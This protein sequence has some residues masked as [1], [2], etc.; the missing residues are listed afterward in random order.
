MTEI[1]VDPTMIERVARAIW[2][3]NQPEGAPAYEDLDFL[4]QGRVKM[5]ARACIRAMRE[6]T[7][8]ILDSTPSVYG[9]AGLDWTVEAKAIWGQMIDAALKED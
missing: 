7:Q 9:G 1:V 3:E 6:P 2:M 4:D 8:E 5:I